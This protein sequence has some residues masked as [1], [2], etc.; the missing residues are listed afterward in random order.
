MSLLSILY[1]V[2]LILA[3]IGAFAVFTYS[4]HVFPL[5]VLLLFIIIGLKS[6]RTPLQ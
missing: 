1:W 3:A 5:A 2:I 4:V 6:F